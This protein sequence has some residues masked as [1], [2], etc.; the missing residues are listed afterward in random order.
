MRS[1][2][3]DGKE[4]GY[5]DQEIVENKPLVFTF[6]NKLIKDEPKYQYEIHSTTTDEVRLKWKWNT[7]ESQFG[8]GYETIKTFDIVNKDY[9]L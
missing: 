5:T 7:L 9:R 6:L 8:I 1:Y 2:D 4:L 3:F